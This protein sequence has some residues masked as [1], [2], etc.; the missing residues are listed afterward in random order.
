MS[1]R[2][3]AGK[4]KRQE[5]MLALVWDFDKGL[6]GIWNHT[7][8]RFPLCQARV[9][10]KKK[11]SKGKKLK[12]PDLSAAEELCLTNPDLFLFTRV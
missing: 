7:Q 4:G 11:R 6:K 8:K 1:W 5:G 2:G 10:V 12:A 3:R 9:R